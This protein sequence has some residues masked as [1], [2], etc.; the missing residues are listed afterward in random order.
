MGSRCAA[1]ATSQPTMQ[2]KIADFLYIG[3]RRGRVTL[4]V[5][6]DFRPLYDK[7]KGVDVELSIDKYHPARSL[8]ANAYL[9]KLCSDIANR[10][11]STK[12]DVY[13]REIREV[14]EYTP[15]PIKEEAVDEFSRIWAAH[16][17][18]WFVEVIDDSKL[19]GYKLVFA[20]QGSSTYDTRQMSRLL[21]NTI[22]D[23]KS[24]GLEVRPK[25]EIESML[26][27]ME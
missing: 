21:D 16:G 12:E 10:V 11:N 20:Y 14:G 19:P 27:E 6:G 4:D 2:A 25:E 8:S 9:W 17:T 22:Q 26:N 23:A 7:F 3:P 18:G 24:L 15:L 13:R 5:A 1:I